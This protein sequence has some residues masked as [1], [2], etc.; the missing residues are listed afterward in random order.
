[1]RMFRLTLWQH[2][3][4][5]GHH[6]LLQRLAVQIVVDLPNVNLLVYQNNST[7]KKIRIDFHSMQECS[8]LGFQG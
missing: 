6:N 1:M 5:H 2:Y 3:T 8:K 4:V 7:K